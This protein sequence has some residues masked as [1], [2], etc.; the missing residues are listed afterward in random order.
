[1][2]RAFYL[3]R[4]NDGSR[5]R[6]F[7]SLLSFPLRFKPQMDTSVSP[8]FSSLTLFCLAQNSYS[9]IATVDTSDIY[10][11]YIRFLVTS[12]LFIF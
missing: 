11:F 2:L 10:F 6:V 5:P 12:H 7:Y 9:G 3:G 8:N 1:M 4:I